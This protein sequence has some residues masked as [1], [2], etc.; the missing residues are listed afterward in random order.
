[1]NKRSGRKN[2]RGS[3][4]KGFCLEEKKERKREK[5]KKEIRAEKGKNERKESVIF[6]CFFLLF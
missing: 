2:K 3:G 5:G 6:G 1:M 4:H